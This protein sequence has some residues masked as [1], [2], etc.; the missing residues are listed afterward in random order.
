M[1]K[2]E[3]H[4]IRRIYRTIIQLEQKINSHFG[5]NLNEAVLLCQLNNSDGMT[6]GEIAETLELSCSNASKVIA[7]VEKQGYVHR[8]IGKEDKRQMN[9]VLTAKGKTLLGKMGCCDIPV[10]ELLREV[11]KS[12]ET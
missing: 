10:P 7:S 2:S 1:N 11:I 5:L 9:V 4:Q 6:S 12:E 8:K 3:I